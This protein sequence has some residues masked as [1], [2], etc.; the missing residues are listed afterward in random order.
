MFGADVVWML[1]IQDVT[2]LDGDLLAGPRSL[3]R[4][5]ADRGEPDREHKPADLPHH[6]SLS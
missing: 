4:Q 6:H 5:N 3:K 1:G 2:E